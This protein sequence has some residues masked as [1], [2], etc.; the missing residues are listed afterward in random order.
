MPKKTFRVGITHTENANK[1]NATKRLREER[2]A[3]TTP[4]KKR[5]QTSDGI[6]FNKETPKQPKHANEG[7]T[8]VQ[9][10]NRK[11]KPI[12][13]VNKAHAIVIKQTGTM[14]YSDMLKKVKSNAELQ[15]VGENVTRIPKELKGEV[16]LEFKQCVREENSAYQQLVEKALSQEE[17][18]TNE[19][20]GSFIKECGSLTENTDLLRV[21][22]MLL[23]MKNEISN[24]RRK[25]FRVFDLVERYGKHSK[26]TKIL[27]NHKTPVLNITYTNQSTA[28]NRVT[29]CTG[30]SIAV[31]TTSNKTNAALGTEAELIEA[32][33]EVSKTVTNSPKPKVIPLIWAINIEATEMKRAVPSILM[34][35]PIGRTKRVI[36]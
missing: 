24:N 30:A 33:V 5:K 7:W 23:C 8:V 26:E 12:K 18:Q 14:T 13:L 4:A 31:S 19:E 28:N 16:L 10:K 2:S 35:Q 9:A 29:S 25:T 22:V 6:N 1:I 36:R 15:K 20:C 11:V 32:A 34:L 3:D 21:V 17:Y 27:K